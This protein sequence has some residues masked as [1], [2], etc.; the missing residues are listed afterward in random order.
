MSCEPNRCLEKQRYSDGRRRKNKD[1]S[2]STHTCQCIAVHV[3]W[4]MIVAIVL[5]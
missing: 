1:G 5:N 3:Q 2:F 4:Y